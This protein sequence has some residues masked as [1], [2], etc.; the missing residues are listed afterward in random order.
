[1]RLPGPR[2]IDNLCAP[3]A[4]LKSKNDSRTVPSFVVCLWKYLNGHKCTPEV[5]L[6]GALVRDKAE[7]ECRNG[8]WQPW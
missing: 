6:S 4:A 7:L 5:S 3:E 1:M 8:R 2:D